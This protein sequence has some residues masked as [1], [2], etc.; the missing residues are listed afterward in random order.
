[1]A[2]VHQ[3]RQGMTIPTLKHIPS[4]D[5]TLA[6]ET[7][8][9]IKDTPVTSR[10]CACPDPGQALLSSYLGRLTKSLTSGGGI[11]T[12]QDRNCDICLAAANM[13]QI[14]LSVMN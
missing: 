1:M 12:D 10:D 5:K 8:Q 11:G 13:T 3:D 9:E 4:F 7:G 6:S 14:Y 2:K